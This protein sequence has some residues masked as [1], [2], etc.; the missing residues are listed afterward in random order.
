[1]WLNDNNMA[2]ENDIYDLAGQFEN[3][4]SE[5]FE[6]DEFYDKAVKVLSE[7]CY[8]LEQ[9]RI[10]EVHEEDPQDVEQY[11]EV[12]GKFEDRGEVP[13]YLSFVLE[14]SGEDDFRPSVEFVSGLDDFSFEE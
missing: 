8:S 3:D 13:S 5:A 6:G 2:R 1:L 10:F 11:L 14:D 7:H 9:E 12:I 4:L